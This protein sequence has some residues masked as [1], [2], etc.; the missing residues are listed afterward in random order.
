MVLYNNIYEG[1]NKGR[2]KYIVVAHNDLQNN[3]IRAKKA[4]LLNK[5]EMELEINN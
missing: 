5:I 4:P 1:G 3:E 2:M